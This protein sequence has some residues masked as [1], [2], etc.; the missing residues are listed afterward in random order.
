MGT[1][2]NLGSLVFGLLSWVIPGLALMLKNKKKIS[3]VLLMFI[4]FL[5]MGF[6]LLFQ[7]MVQQALIAKN[8]TVAI[9]DTIDGVVMVSMVLLCGTILTNVA[10]FRTLT[11]K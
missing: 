3:G 2:L 1:T 9:M 5:L 10:L 6:S 4:S 11:K 8:D 7:L